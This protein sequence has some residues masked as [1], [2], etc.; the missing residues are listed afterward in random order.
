MTLEKILYWTV[1][2]GAYLLPFTLL[3]VAYSMFFP[4]IVG[5]NL[6][7]R[8]IVE[9]MAAAWV[10]LLI[11]DFKKYWS[12][13]N[14]VS[15]ALT[16]FVAVVFV[17]AVFGVDFK[18]SF[19]SNFER[20][21]GLVTLFH[22]LALFFVLTGTLHTRREW[23]FLFTAALTASV[24]I[25]FYGLLEYSGEVN[26]MADSKRIIS[27]LGN[28]L[29]I[30]AYLSFNIFLAA[31]LW[32]YVQS[33]F[34]KWLLGAIIVFELTVFFLTESR[35]A[36]VGMV[37][38]IGIVLFLTLFFM[39]GVKKKILLGCV[40]L[41]ILAIPVVLN[42][43]KDTSFVKNNAFLPRYADITLKAGESRFILW[44]M[45]WESFKERPILGWGMGN[46]SIPYAKYYDPKMFGQEAWFDRTHNMP[47]EWLVTGGIVGFLAYIAIFLLTVPALSQGVKK[48]LLK[49]KT[50]FIFIG[51][52][53]AYVVQLLF[54]FDTLSTYL[55][56][57]VVL[58]F[59][60]AVSISDEEI[61][62]KKN[63]LAL[64]PA[65]LS[66][67]LI[68]QGKY[69]SKKR[70]MEM[71][72]ETLRTANTAHL[73]ITRL[74]AISIAFLVAVLLI[75][76]INVRPVLA[77]RTLIQSL[78]L[79]NEQRFA[80]AFESIGKSLR[81]SRGTIG[82]TEIREHTTFEA[83]KLFSNTEMLEKPGAKDIYNLVLKEMENQVAENSAENPQIKHN[84]LLAQLYQVYAFKYSD[85][86]ILQAA[87][88][89]YER[90]IQFAPHYIGTQ[91]VFANLLARMGNVEGALEYTQKSKNLLENAG[92]YSADIFYSEPLFDVAL[93]RYDEAYQALL[94]IIEDYGLEDNRLDKDMMENIVATSW[95]PGSASIA[96]LKKV[97]LLDT[98]IN[99]EP[100]L[101]A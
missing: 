52:F 6:A 99:S 55:M 63:T 29:Y 66:E 30:A 8:V 16:V 35:G 3:I 33:R 37:A 46:F 90:A 57:I 36:F 9:L 39:E 4:F 50:I 31:F 98:S 48:T 73:S 5:K 42:I 49:R 89:Q 92:H 34:L 64:S 56:F 7:F 22:L 18:N 1:R 77:N 85:E 21:E 41:A 95:A 45:G 75:A 96:F 100:L 19:W 72:K 17:S 32:F 101:L 24:F 54:V 38:G 69:I 94:G 14:F 47:L 78:R 53:A 62:S 91:Q 51:M 44:K 2:I 61:W 27:T 68:P 60:H 58:G 15:I 12:R 79:I 23:F 81:Y 11:I 70:I 71:Q 86:E 10:G 40:L 25:A 28:P 84:I 82:A 76:T 83:Y 67:V 93:E 88:N 65:V 80:D 43:A 26:S 20:M 59:L 97:T 74:S 13:W 87:V